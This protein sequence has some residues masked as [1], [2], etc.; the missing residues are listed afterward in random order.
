MHSS[1][2]GFATKSIR[3]PRWGFVYLKTHILRSR[4]VRDPSRRSP[5][6]FIIKF[7]VSDPA[8]C[9]LVNRVDDNVVVRVGFIGMRSD[10]ILMPW[11]EGFNPLAPDFVELFRRL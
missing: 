11:K 6:R 7:F 10:Y 4:Y 1:I 9:F 5:S 3:F 2:T 8:A